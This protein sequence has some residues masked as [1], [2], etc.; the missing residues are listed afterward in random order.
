MPF[1]LDPKAVASPSQCEIDFVVDNVRYHYG[2]EATD[3]AFSSEWLFA[4]P[5]DRRQALF[6]REDMQF[7]FGRNLKGRNHVISELTRPNS[8]F[9]SAA[10]QNGHDELTKI[11]KFFQSI[12]IGEQQHPDLASSLRERP[13]DERIL[14][15]LKAAGTGIIDYR[16]RDVEPSKKEHDFRKKLNALL[17]ELVPNEGNIPSERFADLQLG[18]QGSE[19]QSVYLN[20]MQESE[21]TQRL[22]RL[23]LPVFT[24]LDAGT[25]MVVDELDASLHTQACELVIALF[26]SPKTN[27]KKAQLLATTHDTN[28]L[29]SAHLRRDQIWLTEKDA[30]GATHLYPLT[31]FRTRKGDN[32]ARGYLQGRY[33]AIP[34]SGSPSDILP[35]FGS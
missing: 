29:R 10:A 3:K 11:S 7:R 26:S 8:L 5:N 13:L 28:L 19:G 21:G 16:V 25:A 17:A 20:L 12:T 6:E 4:Y 22:L 32:L 24:A 15:F 27:P 1:A 34:F 18:H 31:D 35:A 9:L 23:L 14:R 33:G 30:E 2:F